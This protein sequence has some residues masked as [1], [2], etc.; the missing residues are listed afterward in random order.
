MW[1]EI[2]IVGD[3]AV[4]GSEAHLHGIQ[5][6]DMKKLLDLSSATPKIFSQSDLASHWGVTSQGNPDDAWDKL[7]AVGENLLRSHFEINLDLEFSC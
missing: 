7:P 2:R 1:R 5:L 4:I 3:Y 6:F